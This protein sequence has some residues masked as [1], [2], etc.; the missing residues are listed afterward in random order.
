M[1]R[2]ESYRSHNVVR[3]DRPDGSII[4]TSGHE[5]GEVAD[6]TGD[7]LHR[8]AG[9]A[10][11]RVFLA[12]RSGPGWREESY[13]AVLEKVRAI[14]AALVGRGLNADTPILIMSGNGVDHG[15]LSLAAQYAGIPVVPVA[16]Q[17]ALIPG[18]H[19]RL[20]HVIDLVRPSLAYAV[21]AGEYAEAIALKELEGV[22]IVASR[23]GS[24]RATP[25]D[26]LLR[27]DAGIDVDA[28][29]AGVGPDSVVKILMT[30]GSTSHPK[31][32]P[33]THRMMCVNQTQM[34]DAL[35]FLRERPP[36]IVDWLPWNHV[37]GGSHNFNMMLANGGSLYIDDGKP[38]KGRFERTLEN[39]SMVTGTLAFN[40][41]VGFS[42]LLGA[43]RADDSLRRRFFADL[44]LVF[45]AGASLPQE[46]WEGFEQMAVEVKGS[47]PLMT[48]SWGLTETAPACLLQHEPTSRSGIVGVPL[49]GI[50]VKLLPDED[51]RCEVRVKGPNIMSGYIGDAGKAAGSFDEEGYFVTGDAMRF[52]DPERPEKGLRFDG[53]ISEDFKL[54]TG[55]WVRAAALRLDL[56]SCL[57]PLAA[58]LVITGHDRNEIGV[59]V[60]PDRQA[61]ADAGYAPE[62]AGGALT[63]PG[64]SA[65]I[66][67][68]LAERARTATGSST[69]VARALVMAE[70]AS[71]GEGEMT[72]KG[73]LNAR[74]VLTRR[75]ALL[76]RLYDDDDPA[77][78]RIQGA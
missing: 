1:V 11:D 15:L 58:D 78:I 48:S 36:V 38:V 64:L 5:L 8:W 28:V 49:N 18:A 19:D 7:W 70:P 17:Y 75:A 41:P 69:R 66:A 24:S 13:S 31:G 14:A 60:F 16:E 12:E 39:L 26:D 10:P 65:E 25:F 20:R 47:V 35:P 51:M 6:T 42:M 30:S 56:L 59:L 54:L 61:L 44:D 67:R 68:R 27:G 23:P 37:F 46:V 45:Y 77:T 3:E 2:T 34:A 50:S 43:L 33:T 22:E 76:D 74:K 62:E 71:L 40:V 29:H 32:V 73:S 72:A 21:D 53:R 55:T 9:E 4:L 52:V 63:D 57:S